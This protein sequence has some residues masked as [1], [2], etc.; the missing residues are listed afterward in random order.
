[1]KAV[2]KKSIGKRLLKVN[3]FANTVIRIES[4]LNTR[5]ITPVDDDT[6]DILRPIDFIN[7]K[8][9]MSPREDSLLTESD[10]GFPKFFGGRRELQAFYRK[11]EES[12]NRF[13]REWTRR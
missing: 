7:P 12:I 3:E 8:V 6:M 5:P 4:I 10:H 13:Q 2:M 9:I 11:I 1:M